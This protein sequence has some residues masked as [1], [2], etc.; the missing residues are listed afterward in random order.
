MTNPCACC[1]CTSRRVKSSGSHWTRNSSTNVNRLLCLMRK[2]V[3]LARTRLMPA[4]SPLAL[5]PRRGSLV[6]SAFRL[7][8]S[9]RLSAFLRRGDGKCSVSLGICTAL[10][11]VVFL[12]WRVSALLRECC[13]VALYSVKSDGVSGLVVQSSFRIRR[14]VGAMGRSQSRAFLMLRFTFFL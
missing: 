3:H 11:S 2:G 5:L 14:N 7:R 6:V 13:R 8:S 10:F 12:G 1:I 9:F 4:F